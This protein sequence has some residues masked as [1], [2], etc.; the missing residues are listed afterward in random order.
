MPLDTQE[1]LIFFASV[2]S[3]QS[4]LREITIFQCVRQVGRERGAVTDR[5]RDP[6]SE[7]IALFSPFI[8]WLVSYALVTIFLFIELRL[9]VGM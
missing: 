4:K 9:H 8:C 5:H 1:V 3:S 2:Q 7:M 6:C